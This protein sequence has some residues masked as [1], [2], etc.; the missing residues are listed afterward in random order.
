MTTLYSQT[1]GEAIGE[2]SEAT[3]QILVER[4]PGKYCYLE[5]VDFGSDSDRL[6]I[7][8]LINYGGTD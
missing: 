7:L 5:P 2:F 1:T 8:D 4:A 6:D 3:C